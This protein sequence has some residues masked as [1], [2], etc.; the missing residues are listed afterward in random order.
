MRIKQDFFSG[1]KPRTA[2]GLIQDYEAQIAQNCY[3]GRGDLRPF[4]AYS[5]VKSLTET[6]TLQSLYLWKTS[7][8]DY[9]IASTA[10]LDFARSPIAGE[11]NHRVYYTGADEPRV[12]SSHN[13]S[14]PFDFTTDYY[15]LG[16]PAPAAALT[17]D[18]GYTPGAD[19]RAYVYT[20]V[21]ML[22]STDAE[23]GPP[24]AV[25]SI[26]DYGS[27]DVTLS[28]FTE[29]PTG[30]EIG[31]IRIYRVAA[32]GSGLA[33]FEYVGEFETSGVDFG[34]YTFTDDVADADLGEAIST[35]E[36]DPPPSTLKGLIALKNGSFAGFVGNRVYFSEPFLPHAWPYSYP[37]DAQIVGLG[38]F[39]STIVVLT[40]EYPY[41]MTGQPEAIQTDKMPGRYPCIAKASIASCEMGVIFASS[42]GFVLI[43]NDG[44]T[45]LTYEFLDKNI[46]SDTY[47]PKTIKGAY[48]QG[49]YFGFHV[50][51]I[52][53]Y[54]LRDKAL[55]DITDP[56]SADAV[57]VTLADAQH[58]SDVD[59]QLYF[60]TDDDD[61]SGS[62][63][64]KFEGDSDDYLEYTYRSK[65]FIL[66]NITNFSVARVLRDR[67]F[68]DAINDLITTNAA[69]L[70][71]N[72]ALLAAGGGVGGAVNVNLVDSIVVNYDQMLQ[73]LDLSVDTDITFKLYADG[74]LVHT[75]TVQSDE[76][77][78]LPSSVMYKRCFFELTG[79]LAV[80]E[81]CLANAV[82]ELDAASA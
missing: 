72:Q 66:S 64:Y 4:R 3:L 23:E 70:A 57:Y 19:Y 61:G 58:I 14:S 32:S 43:N 15:K 53:S 39:G 65:E 25:A 47:Y 27:G 81:I 34:T 74:T 11:A 24:S 17:I 20:Y 5:K 54:D 62:A 42:E 50:N 82:E 77:F 8:I 31:K 56:A 22:D 38:I 45:L 51:G 16:V 52:F 55:V 76:P 2:P 68:Y 12:L 37:I 10:A 21:V 67:I 78:R 80:T 26:D 6:G 35:V 48:Y 79:Y 7:S 29:P 30:R 13:I 60:I 9:W 40:D 59:D 69:N 33:D 49:K 36:W 73:V 1:I 18:A 46:F 71:T 75:E 63:I 28:A 41:I 44:P